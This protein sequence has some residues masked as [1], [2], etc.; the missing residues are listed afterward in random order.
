MF[1][2]PRATQAL[3]RPILA[4]R[5]PGMKAC[6]S[7]A[8][9]AHLDW[10][11]TEWHGFVFPSSDLPNGCIDFLQE[12][13]LLRSLWEECQVGR[14]V[15][16]HPRSSRLQACPQYSLSCNDWGLDFMALDWVMSREGQTDGKRK[17][18]EM[19]GGVITSQIMKDWIIQICLYNSCFP[20]HAH[21]HL[22]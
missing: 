15:R 12:M 7:S 13:H 6:F 10:W 21:L 2:D 14:E 19:G 1:L 17:K 16:E 11:I 9:P 4:P 18:L 3:W 22:G 20:W 8:A 5:P